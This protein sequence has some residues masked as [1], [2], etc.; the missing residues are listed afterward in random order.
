MGSYGLII[1]YVVAGL[2]VGYYFRSLT[3]QKKISNAEAEADKIIKKAQAK[4]EEAGKKEKEIVIL[5]KEEASKIRERA[6]KEEQQRRREVSELDTRLRQKDD[7][8]DKRAM[9]LD[10]KQELVYEQEKQNALWHVKE[11][12]LSISLP[13]WHTKLSDIK[14]N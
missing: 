14:S 2:L 9:E 8:L 6:E 5:A 1:I 11:I 10:K 12:R 7:L 3:T 4:L 13:L